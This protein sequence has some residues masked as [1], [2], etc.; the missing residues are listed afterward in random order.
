MSF[1]QKP[2][3][4][5]FLGSVMSYS[6]VQFSWGGMFETIGFEEFVAWQS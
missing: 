1:F 3:V 4:Q 2:R 6:R 5:I